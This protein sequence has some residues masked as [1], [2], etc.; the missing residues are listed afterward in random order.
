ML[1]VYNENIQ[2]FLLYIGRENEQM[3]EE[4]RL[5][6]VGNTGK[7]T[8]K[9]SAQSSKDYSQYFQTTYIPPDLKQAKKR[10]KEDVEIHY[11]FEIPED[12]KGIGKDKKFVIRTYGCQM[13]EHD[14]ENM[15]GI[16]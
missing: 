11:D 10:G 14:S 5:G 1:Y 12:M 6:K 8:D 2:L 13:N 16:L 4:Q 7:T 3:N 9:K 15:A